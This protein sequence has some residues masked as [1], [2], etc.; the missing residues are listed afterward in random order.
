MGDSDYDFLYSV[1]QEIWP[2]DDPILKSSSSDKDT[3][4]VAKTSDS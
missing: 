1:H 2:A 3:V 4:A